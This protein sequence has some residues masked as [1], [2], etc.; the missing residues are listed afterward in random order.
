[1][2][3]YICPYGG[4]ELPCTCSTCKHGLQPRFCVQ[5]L[6]EKCLDLRRRM[7]EYWRRA[8]DLEE[9]Q[10]AYDANEKVP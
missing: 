8:M 1:M 7:K 10:K 2:S 9:Q 5:C 4:E 3:D 6:G